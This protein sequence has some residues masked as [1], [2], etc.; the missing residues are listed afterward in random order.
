M[1]HN[2]YRYQDFSAEPESISKVE[3]NPYKIPAANEVIPKNKT[4]KKYNIIRRSQHL[5]HVCAEACTV[6]TSP[7]C[8]LCK[9]SNTKQRSVIAM[10][11]SCKLIAHETAGDIG[12]TQL[13]LA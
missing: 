10:T 3:I 5:P 2:K 11:F 1:T 8:I 7:V 12:A 4:G 6:T 13:E 9:Y